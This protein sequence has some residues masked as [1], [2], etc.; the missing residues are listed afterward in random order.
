M[1][2]PKTYVLFQLEEGNFIH[3]NIDRD[4]SKYSEEIKEKLNCC[5]KKKT[6]FLIP[7]NG[8]TPCFLINVEKILFIKFEDVEEKYGKI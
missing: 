3:F 2:K 1:E 6:P 4:L 8:K 7:K 5:K